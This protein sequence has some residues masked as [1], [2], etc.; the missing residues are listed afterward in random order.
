MAKEDWRLCADWLVRCQILASNH[1]VTQG[2][3]EVFELAQLLRD[4]VL[5]CHLLNKL[6][7]GSIDTKDFSQRPQMC[8]VCEKTS[9]KCWILCQLFFVILSHSVHLLYICS[10]FGANLLLQS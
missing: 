1:P 9:S 2:H 3:T 5:L 6:K 10:S 8:Q 7:P 4:G